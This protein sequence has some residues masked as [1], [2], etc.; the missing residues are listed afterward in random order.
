M[1]AAVRRIGVG[2]VGI[3]FGRAVH[4][5]AL[6]LDPRFDVRAICASTAPRARRIAEECGIP[7]A[8]GDWRELLAAPGIEAVTI[9]VPPPLQPEI[10]IAALEQGKHVFCE[11]PLADTA[12]AAGQMAAR[13]AAGRL[14]NMVDF[15]FTACDA[16]RTAKR[17]VESRH[18]GPLRQIHADWHVE[19]YAMQHRLHSWKTDVAGGGTLLSFA[20]HSFH[21]LEW[22][23]GPIR[24]LRAWLHRHGEEPGNADSMAQLQFELRDG[25]AGSL[26]ASSNAPFG[27]GHRLEIYGEEGAIHLVNFTR[28]YLDGFT[29]RCI[30][31]QGEVPLPPADDV[32]SPGIAAVKDGRIR[33]VAEMVGRFGD[34]IEKDMPAW[35]DF[36]DGLRVQFLLDLARE[37]QA[38]GKW[39]DVT[40]PQA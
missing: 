34:A 36:R 40:G 1:A 37:S 21:Y 33:A 11:K 6:R 7:Q 32:E 12:V 29:V 8:Y 27:S 16:W 13:A 3:G 10:A 20:S 26:T 15:E 25:A 35:P 4:L 31:R 19:T 5:P 17:A 14:A 22:L 30:N 2:I 9:A 38:T 23:A 18:V 24:R 28:D 39:I